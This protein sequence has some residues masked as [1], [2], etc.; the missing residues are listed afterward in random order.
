MFYKKDFISFLKCLL[1]V[2]KLYSYSHVFETPCSFLINGDILRT[3][4]ELRGLMHFLLFYGLYFY[5][6]SFQD[7]LLRSPTCL[8]LAIIS[9][10]HK[11]V[12]LNTLFLSP[13]FQFSR[14]YVFFDRIYHT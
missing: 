8:K 1:K 14:I 2:N 10:L 3:V 6:F 4:S 12:C 7:R 5:L 9:M 13:C 11:G